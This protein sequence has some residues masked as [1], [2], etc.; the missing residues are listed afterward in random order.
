MMSSVQVA[1]GE[2]PEITRR[3]RARY[4]QISTQ[5]NISEEDRLREMR[6]IE[7]I[8]ASEAERVRLGYLLGDAARAIPEV[9]GTVEHRIRMLRLSLSDKCRQ[10][11]HLLDTL[12]PL[13]L[14]N[15][16]HCRLIREGIVNSAGE[17]EELSSRLEQLMN[18][19][20][21]PRLVRH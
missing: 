20:R 11:E 14:N 13:L 2:M 9:A 8:S 4:H 12:A 10:L 6:Y 7:E 17:N 18:R 5:E 16:Q 1:K 15:C 3:Y 21:K 19:Q